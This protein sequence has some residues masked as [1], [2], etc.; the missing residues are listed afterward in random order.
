MNNPN[1][2]PFAELV[3]E[4]MRSDKEGEKIDDAFRK[5]HLAGTDFDVLPPG[6]TFADLNEILQEHAM[7]LE[8][9]E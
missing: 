1:M 6:A 7:D 9:E 2:P 3:L 5:D 4:K 8:D